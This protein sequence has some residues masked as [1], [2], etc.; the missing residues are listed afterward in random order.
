[1]SEHHSVTL[2]RA[3][4]QPLGEHARLARSSAVKV[5]G[6]IAWLLWAVVHIMFIVEFRN[7]IL[8]GARWLWNWLLHARDNKADHWIV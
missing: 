6:F 5:Y 1:M 7:R 4:S 8:V 3:R 2:I